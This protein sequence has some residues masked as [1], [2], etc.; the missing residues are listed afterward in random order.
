MELNCELACSVNQHRLSSA[1]LR[2]LSYLFNMYEYKL[3]LFHAFKQV[4]FFFPFNMKVME[5]FPV[6]SQMWKSSLISSKTEIAE[7]VQQLERKNS[8][9]M[10]DH[11]ALAQTLSN[12]IEMQQAL[13]WSEFSATQPC[14]PTTGVWWGTLLLHPWTDS[15]G[16]SGP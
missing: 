2:Q 14:C 7:A 12:V 13:C 1:I 5:Q 10:M 3:P 11:L 4:F 6:P 8:F 16:Y 9:S 15:R